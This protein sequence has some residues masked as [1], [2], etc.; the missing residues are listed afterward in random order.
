IPADIDFVFISLHHP[1]VTSAGDKTNGRGGSSARPA[2]QQLAAFLEQQQ[3]NIRPRI[4]VF[5]SHV[6]NY[7][8]HE[9]GGVTYFV[10][11]GGGAH[12]YPISRSADD[13]FRSAE[14]NYH[15]LLVEV[16][17]G[18]V[19][20]TMNRVEIKDGVAKWTRP[21]SVV[22]SCPVPKRA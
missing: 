11:G 10:T 19:K 17:L 6:H 7:E 8:R 16:R 21:D 1:P 3:Q 14:I 18:K 13:S 12:A 20:V 22:I 4:V 9:R 15:Y 2:E 5:A